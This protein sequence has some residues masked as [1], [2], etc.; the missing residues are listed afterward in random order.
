MIPLPHT[1]PTE[2]F[3]VVKNPDDKFASP[4]GWHTDGKT[5]Y[6]VTRGNNINLYIPVKLT[7][8][9]GKPKENVEYRANGGETL[10]FMSRWR[11]DEKPSSKTN[12]DTSEVIFFFNFYIDSLVLSFKLSA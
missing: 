1:N 8:S 4:L 5:N 2:G 10:E 9:K 6:T 7:L 12:R 3:R 11:P